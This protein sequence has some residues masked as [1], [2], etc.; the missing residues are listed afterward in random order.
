MEDG[1]VV[2]ALTSFNQVLCPEDPSSGLVSVEN[3]PILQAK[4]DDPD[5]VY[6][7]LAR[8]KYISESL[9]QKYTIVTFYQAIYC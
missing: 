5:T 1:Q 4:A 2:P 8:C 7:V 9:G 3:M 6:T